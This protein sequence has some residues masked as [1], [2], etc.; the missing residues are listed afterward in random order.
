M[1]AMDMGDGKAPQRTFKEKLL[2]TLAEA[3]LDA[4]AE[5]EEA[6][7]DKLA[8]SVEALVDG[9]PAAFV[10]FFY[11]CTAGDG[12]ADD[13][14]TAEELEARRIDP[15]RFEHADEVPPE[16]MQFLKD[17]LVMADTASRRGDSTAV[18]EC[19]K[20]L[21]KY[22]TGTENPRKAVFF[23]AKCL[24]VASSSGGD[25]AAELEAN[26][27]LGAAHEALGD[28]AAAIASFERQMALAESSGDD[29][30][31]RLGQSNLVR[32]YRH[33]ADARAAAGDGEG[34][35]LF[36]EKCLKVAKSGGDP[37][38][39]GLANHRLGLAYHSE[40]DYDKAIEFQT[41]YLRL[42]TALGD[43]A[44]EG[45]ARRSLA[46]ANQSLNDVDGAVAHL[47][48]FLE[49]AK[50]G[51][52]A[53]QARACCSLGKIYSAAGKFD[54]AV[55]YFERFFEVAR[56]LNDRR[57]LDVAR[58]NLGIARGSARGAGLLRVVA[59]TGG[60]G[61]AASP[62]GEDAMHALMAWKNVRLP[63]NAAGA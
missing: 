39:E 51:D 43:R 37:S 27:N 28:T 48:A 18:S 15:D 61:E 16:S 42:C 3:E 23:F 56:S 22:F 9:C 35:V 25:P 46:A 36:L 29:G 13:N 17:T 41:E 57:M 6:H 49:I 47:E 1:A 5:R 55:H 21:A 14:Y 2:D 62:Q 44:G 59:G 8:L 30:E 31:K 11:L 10:D 54:R 50:S 32:V 7:K 40:G 63:L 20:T 45:A 24:E 12:V 53:S 26:A 19:Y 60:P 33:A 38:S 4:S 58:V 34:S 52:P